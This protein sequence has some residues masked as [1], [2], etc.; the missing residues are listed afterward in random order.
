MKNLNRVTSS[1]Q[2]YMYHSVSD[3]GEHNGSSSSFSSSNPSSDTLSVSFSPAHSPSTHLHFQQSLLTLMHLRFLTRL[4]QSSLEWNRTTPLGF[5][6]HHFFESALQSTTVFFQTNTFHITPEDLVQLC[7]FASFFEADVRSIFL[8]IDGS[9]KAEQFLNFSRV[10]LGLELRLENHNDLIFLKNDKNF[11]I[12]FP[13]LKQL[14]VKVHRR[15]SLAY[16]ELLKVNTAITSID[17]R[18]NSI[19]D[20]GARALAEVLRVNT[21]VTSIDLVRNAIGDDGARTLAEVLKIN[22]TVTKID[23]S[24]NYIGDKGARALADALKVNTAVT[25][26]DMWNNSIGDE[27]VKAL[28]D[29][30][31]VNTAV[32][33]IDF[34]DNSI[35]AEGARALADALKVNTVI[36]RLNLRSNSIGNEGARALA[37]ALKVNSTVTSVDL[38]NNSIAA[39]GARALAELLIVN[40][41]VKIVGVNQL[42]RH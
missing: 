29:A 1:H 21:V 19:G 12:F 34:G 2:N 40:N 42:D 8:H 17:L 41:N 27:G 18:Y 23:L 39:E 13:L 38:W 20:E 30:F 10:I 32:T 26:L 14:H 35:G 22:T 33:R 11:S 31:K 36:T 15:I 7:A 3:V 37:D 24:K 16:I 6:S 9:F 25:S 4:L 28:A 5:V